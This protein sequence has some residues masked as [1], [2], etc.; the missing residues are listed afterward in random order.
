MIGVRSGFVARMKDVAA[1]ATFTHCMIHRYALGVKTLPSDLLGVFKD[2]VKIIN[3]I[4]GHATNSRLF[5]K[6]CDEVGAKYNALLYF[7][8]VRWLS[9][10]KCLTRVLQMREEI[11]MLLKNGRSDKERDMYERISNVDFVRKLAYLS[12][13]FEDINSVNL[14]LQGPTVNMLAARDRVSGF[15][16]RLELYERRA[17]VGDV[18]MFTEL[19]LLEGDD[20]MCPF[21]SDIATHIA[22]VRQALGQYLPDMSGRGDVWAV[23]CHWHHFC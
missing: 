5:R 13:F 21:A 16:K 22:S 6:L 9:R 7:T 23:H 19:S 3:H 18:S 15:V 20:G 2:V 11:C 4:R 14:S 12:D 8:E 10:G 1:H 17:G